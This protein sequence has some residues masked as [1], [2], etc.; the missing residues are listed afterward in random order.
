MFA[1]LAR[2]TTLQRLATG[3][4][5]MTKITGAKSVI[6]AFST[7]AQISFNSFPLITAFLCFC[8]APFRSP[9]LFFSMFRLC[10]SSP[11]T[12]AENRPYNVIGHDEGGTPVHADHLER[13]SKNGEHQT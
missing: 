8:G 5:G 1:L 3:A 4:N 7:F 9:S 12:S 11:S 13:R 2:G 10:R 6:G